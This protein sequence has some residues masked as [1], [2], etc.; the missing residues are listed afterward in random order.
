M[1]AHRPRPKKGD[2]V[3]ILTHTKLDKLAS[4]VGTVLQCRYKTDAYFIAPANSPFTV[5]PYWLAGSQ[6]RVI[7]K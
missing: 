7:D 2:L 6:L 4:F 5:E 1:S 3:K